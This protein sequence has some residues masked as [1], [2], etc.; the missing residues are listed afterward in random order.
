MHKD[1]QFHLLPCGSTV[2]ETML[3]RCHLESPEQSYHHAYHV[4]AVEYMEIYRP[5]VF[6]RAQIQWAIVGIFLLSFNQVKEKITQGEYY[7]MQ[8]IMISH[9]PNFRLGLKWC[10]TYVVTLIRNSIQESDRSR[11]TK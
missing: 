9:Y 6:L 10:N 11:I 8:L 4:S 1:L 7:N 3:R 5:Q 2:H